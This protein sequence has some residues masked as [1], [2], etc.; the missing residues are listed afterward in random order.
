MNKVMRREEELKARIREKLREF[1]LYRSEHWISVSIP[2]DAVIVNYRFDS[3]QHSD[4]NREKTQFSLRIRGSTGHLHYMEVERGFTGQ[5]YGEQLYNIIEQFCKE[6]G[7]T[8]IETSKPVGRAVN[9][10]ARMGFK[11]VSEISQGKTITP[12]N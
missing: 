7:C 1:P 11:P 9:F 5:G 4:L 8:L 6:M 2:N 12:N 3:Y 10:W